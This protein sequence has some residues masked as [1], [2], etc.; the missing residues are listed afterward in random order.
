MIGQGGSLGSANTAAE[1]HGAILPYRGESSH[2]HAAHYMP[3]CT[4]LMDMKTTRREVPM[5]LRSTLWT[6]GSM[7]H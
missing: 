7:G 4:K 2:P 6:E 3:F 1:E 5:Q